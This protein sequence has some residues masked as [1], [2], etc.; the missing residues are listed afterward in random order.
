MRR[1]ARPCALGWDLSW[2]RGKIHNAFIHG[3]AR[4]P[5]KTKGTCPM[6]GPSGHSSALSS[7]SRPRRVRREQ[8][9]RLRL[10]RHPLTRDSFFGGHVLGRARRTAAA[11][12]WQHK[13]AHVEALSPAVGGPRRRMEDAALA[14]IAREAERRAAPQA[15]K[16]VPRAIVRASRRQ[17]ACRLLRTREREDAGASVQRGATVPASLGGGTRSKVCATS[18]IRNVDRPQRAAAAPNPHQRAAAINCTWRRRRRAGRCAQRTRSL[19]QCGGR[20]AV[21]SR[22]HATHQRAAARFLHG[23]ARLAGIAVLRART[24]SPAHRHANVAA[25]SVPPAAAAKG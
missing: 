11:A 6:M 21:S 15:S 14:A 20:F 7:G 4:E 25:P 19:H 13:L 16:K 9:R 22:E 2:W 8:R 24:G 18:R 23:A 17:V 10:P 12:A 3:S 5:A 1:S